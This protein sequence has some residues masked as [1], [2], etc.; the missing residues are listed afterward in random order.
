MV[1]PTT[2]FPV[3]VPSIVPPLLVTVPEFVM[4]P[5]IVPPVFSR[6][7]ELVI[8][9][10][11]VPEELFVILPPLLFVIAPS[12]VKSPVFVIVP[13]FVVVP[14]TVTVPPELL[15]VP[16]FLIA[17]SID[18]SL[19]SAFVKFAPDWKVAAPLASI[20]PLLVI[21]EFPSPSISVQMILFSFMSFPPA[22][23]FIIKLT[24]SRFWSVPLFKNSP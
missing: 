14:F 19:V 21:L 2:S 22:S 20:V 8:V 17:P 15:K 23:T 9:P 12:E 3:T 4:S 16:S 10:E 24:F 6:E 11:I 7:P 18:N 5:V 13:V 1:P